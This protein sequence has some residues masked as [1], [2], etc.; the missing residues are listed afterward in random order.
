[1][2]YELAGLVSVAS[3][4]GA[5]V[6]RSPFWTPTSVPENVGLAAPTVREALAAVAVNGTGTTTI[7]PGTYVT[8]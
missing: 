7:V 2:T 3:V 1:M 5:R 6:I 8:V 4:T